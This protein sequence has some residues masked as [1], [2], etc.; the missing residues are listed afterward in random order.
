[1][2]VSEQSGEEMRSA[3]YLAQYQA[4][5]EVVLHAR[6]V[7]HSVVAWSTAAA[8][9]LIGSGVVLAGAGAESVTSGTSGIAFVLLFSIAIPGLAAGSFN[10]WLGEIARMRRAA[11]FLRDIEYTVHM[12]EGSRWPPLTYDTVA[13]RGPGGAGDS[14]TTGG[15]HAVANL[16]LGLFVMST[17]VASASL[18]NFDLPEEYATLLR[19]VGQV[20]LMASLA[21][22]VYAI[23]NGFRTVAAYARHSPTRM[24]EEFAEGL[25]DR[26][27]MR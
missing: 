24:D 21:G 10:A 13:S 27:D 22:F 11:S 16:Y 6:Q 17:A 5:R 23:R 14:V 7:Q 26:Q 18:W 8:G 20:L 25:F 4:V 12:A 3:L 2:P 15:R 19:V 1:V 9:V